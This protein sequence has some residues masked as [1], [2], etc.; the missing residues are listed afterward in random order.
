MKR[1]R[2]QYGCLTRKHHTISED[3]W[4]FRFYETLPDGRRARRARVVGTVKQ[5]PTRADALR[6]IE[7]FRV[8]LNLGHRYGRPLT[9]RALVTRYIE[10][11]LPFRR[12][13]TQQSYR[14][15]L[16][17]WIS[18]K[19]GDFLL[20]QVTP[21]AVEQ[22]LRSVSLAPKTKVNLRTIFHVIYTY[23]LRW[24]FTDRNPIALVRQSGGRRAIPRII[25]VE[26]IRRLL[27]QLDPPYR[28]MVL[29][30][31]SL[32][33][34][35]SEIMGLQWSDFDWAN[36]T[37]LIRRGVVNGR[38]GDTKTEASRKALPVDS[39]LADALRELRRCQNPRIRPGDWVFGNRIGRPR[40]QQD[41]LRR[42]IRPAALRAGLGKIG[43]HTF[44]H[45][46]STL[47]RGLGADIKVQ[48]ELLRHSTVQSTM[49]VYTQAI[50]EQKRTAN[51]AVVGLLFG[52][53][54]FALTNGNQQVLTAARLAFIESL[55]S[56]CYCG[57]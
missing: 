20:D 23:A 55:S 29:I 37:V 15:A 12:H 32:G 10:Q 17:R 36:H 42:H 7:P 18:P 16:K 39:I 53:G 40:S 51:S 28:T 38:S 27:E 43:W 57:A 46:Y 11:E 4:Q 13:S 5:Y 54:I 19:W 30:A 49:N 33:L 41:I 45:S 50:S 47:L 21:L 56:D 35:A 2:Y 1:R 26:E 3:V 14:S 48:Q 25:T 6:A 34:R 31:A 22:W 52:R 24:N 8:W 9:I 44:R